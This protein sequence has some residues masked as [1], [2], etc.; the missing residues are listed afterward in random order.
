MSPRIQKLRGAIET[1]HHCTARHAAS[2]RVTAFFEGQIA[3]VG[4]VERFDL[5]AHPKAKRCYGWS[6]E[7]NGETQYVTA[8]EVPPVV[9]AETAVNV[10]IAAKAGA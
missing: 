5:T 2:E 10:A 1:M 3:W 9:S 6:Y 4:V 8:M 7:E